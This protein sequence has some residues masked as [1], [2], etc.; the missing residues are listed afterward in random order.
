[1][2]KFIDVNTSPFTK[3]QLRQFRKEIEKSGGTDE[4]MIEKQALKINNGCRE[5]AIY[6]D[7]QE[8]REKY[9]TG[10]Y[11]PLREYYNTEVP[12]VFWSKLYEMLKKVN[13]KFQ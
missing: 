4:L 9:L 7:I 1:M 10:V 5:I 6:K 8:Y 2:S 11:E 3:K 12:Y 13:P